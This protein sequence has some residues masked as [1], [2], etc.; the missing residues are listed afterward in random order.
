MRPLAVLV[1]LTLA[2]CARK[3]S[4]DRPLK[5]P[6]ALK[7]LRLSE[8]FRVELFAAEPDV[9][10]PVEMV[11][12]E[13]GR[14]YVAEMRDYP[15]DPPPGRP[16]RSRIRLLEDADGD[17]KFE[18]S[19]IFADQVL[20]VSGLMPWKGGLI[21]TSAPDILFLK[22][23]DGDGKADVREVLYTGFPKVN[24]EAR[25]TNLRL[26]VDNWIYAA[27]EGRDGQ[28]VSPEH[29][30]RPPVRVRGADFRF[31]P[32]R[33]L[34]ESA[35]GP[36]QFGM[37]FDDWGNRFLTQNTIHV[38]HAV[39]PMNYLARAPLLETGAVS[40]DISDHGSPSAPL[41]PLTKPQA[42]RE[43][44]TRLRQQRYDENQLNR[45]EQVGGFFTAAS[46]GTVY[47][48]DVF[49]KEYWGNLFTGDVNGNLVHRDILRPSGVTFTASRAKDKVEFLASTDS[50]FRPCNFANAPDGNLYMIDIYREFI[51]T[52]ESIP[53]EIKKN[54][55]FYSGDTMGRVYRLAPSQP[56]RKRGLRAGLGR[57]TSVELVGLLNESN[58]WHRQTAQ[59]LLLERQDKSAVPAL[60]EL[61]ARSE[62][63][64]G[65]LH[66]L[67]M[68]EGLGALEAAEVRRALSDP[69]AGIRE[70]ALRLSEGFLPQ[71][72]GDVLKLA[73]DPEPR[74]EF[75]LAFTLGQVKSAAAAAALAGIAK[76]HGEDK[77]FRVAI[78]SSVADY[79]ARFLELTQYNAALLPQLAALVGSRRQPGEIA[80]LLGAVG[81]LEHPEA[82]L[83]GLARGLRLV[84]AK[85][86]KAGAAETHL[87]RLLDSPSEPVQKAAWEVARYFE[88]RAVVAKAAR[89][90]LDAAIGVNR[91][92]RSVGALRGGQ[93]AES[94]AVLK[95]VLESNPPPELQ[96]AAVDSLAAFDDPGVGP[97]ILSY[98]RGYSPDART[99]AIGALLGAQSR[100]P[101][102]LKAL[103]D[104]QVEA[105]ALDVAA[106]ARLIE[107]GDRAR[108]LVQTQAGERAKLVESYRDALKVAG[109]VTRGKQLF[110]E[111]C[112]KCHMPRK[113][114]GRV[115]P[116]LSGIN[117]KT[118]E[119][120][121][122]SI[123]DPSYAIEPRYE[124]DETILRSSIA[125]IR[126]SA[127][128]LMPEELEK[129]LG[130]Q[131]LADVIA[132][133]RGGL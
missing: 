18:R 89:D 70:H 57:M 53:D 127:I 12:D 131:G 114:G 98:W 26:G 109:D 19:V 29:P 82:G 86:V 63:P 62:N 122:T 40:V 4:G 107:L 20:E 96:V 132:Y 115:G 103:E 5:P 73:G 125:E 85:G 22:D 67:W 54:M 75:Q 30:E 95:K 36:T 8:D 17:G 102:L 64:L 77:W 65:R 118:R 39:A 55:N 46:G 101:V 104:R 81:K 88:L 37:T 116:D 51:E 120:L 9:V 38:R 72:A 7:S 84:G 76:R 111:N 28:I 121:L 66:A 13:N 23:T 27:N 105:A 42:W 35:S 79:P 31:H 2:A 124:G 3:P 112:A 99:H 45:I 11:F 110:D 78:L 50:W 60:R 87:V 15:D 94:S 6:E 133:L 117:N 59:R 129:P 91:R 34:S 16:A 1:L 44:R 48:G 43:Q 14:V 92:I 21:V 119:E 32:I 52:P 108:R 97:A 128:S 74:V 49:P 113:Q 56:L 61:A 90:A 47:N 71:L 83:E 123:I 93:Y 33:G 80:Q 130:K 41:F 24:P 100:I 68:L 126:S 69:H 106:R 10:D 25:I 58:G